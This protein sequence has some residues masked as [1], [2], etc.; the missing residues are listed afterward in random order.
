VILIGSPL[1]ALTT[2]Y[3][4]T[5]YFFV[6][7]SKENTNALKQ[8][9]AASPINDRV[10]IRTGDCNELVNDIVSYIRTDERHS[11]NL[12]FL[13]PE[14]MELQWETVAKLATVRRMDLIINYPQGGLTRSM[15]QAFEKESQTA[16]DNFFGDREWRKIYQDWRNKG[17]RFGIHRQLI[18]LYKGKLQALGYK[19][20]L[21][22]DQV[23]DEPLIRNAR[24]RAPLY[25]LLFASKHPLGYDFWQKVT[26]K[27]IYGQRSLF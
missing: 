26:R 21:Q 4:F 17:K 18:D 12:A 2:R 15:L 24:R 5:R 1:L 8:R 20:V 7:N 6:D 14:G 22:D 27:D 16:V 19:E 10:D 23:G 9:C 13:D 3:P 11:L 25:R